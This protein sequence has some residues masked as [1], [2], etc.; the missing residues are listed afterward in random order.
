MVGAVCE[1]DQGGRKDA[2]SRGEKELENG[3][4]EWVWKERGQKNGGDYEL[5]ET[6]WGQEGRGW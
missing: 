1:G 3:K 4:I 2:M 5:E 6:E